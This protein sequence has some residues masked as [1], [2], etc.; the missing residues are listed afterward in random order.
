MDQQGAHVPK[1]LHET[2]DNGTADQATLYMP[3]GMGLGWQ[4]L[5]VKRI[6]WSRGRY[7][8]YANAINLVWRQ[9][10]QK[11][12]RRKWLSYKPQ[13]VI[14]A[15][16]GHPD[17]PSSWEVIK[18][19]Q[20][21]TIKR[22]K[23]SSFDPG[24]ASDFGQWLDLQG[25]TILADFREEETG[26]QG[27]VSL[28]DLG[29]PANA[30]P[31]P[32]I[33]TPSPLPDTPA[34]PD[35]PSGTAESISTTETAKLI[36]KRLKAD[37][38]RATFY[39]RSKSYSMGASI[40]VYWVDGPT[41][42][43]VK[44][45]AGDYDGSG[46]DGMIDL[47]YYINHWLQPDGSTI[48]AYTSGTGGSG[49][50]N[51]AISNPKPHKK[52]R[53]VSFGS[54][55]VSISRY[56]SA[57]FLQEAGARI[58]S[59]TGWE[60][61][62]IEPNTAWISNSKQLPVAQFKY[63]PDLLIPG[64]LDH[65]TLDREFDNRISKISAYK[66]PSKPKPTPSTPDKP[67]SGSGSITPDQVTVTHTS[68]NG[69]TWTW[70]ECPKP[71][72]FIRQALKDRGFRWSWKRRQWYATTEISRSAVLAIL[73]VDDT[74]GAEPDN[75]PDPP[76]NGPQPD[77]PAK[78]GTVQD[79]PKRDKLL[80]LATSYTKAI[81]KKRSTFANS[82]LTPRRARFI[83]SANIDA[84][85]MEQAQQ[86]LV[87]LADLWFAGNVPGCL[88]KVRTKKDAH[89]LAENVRTREKWG[90]KYPSS[91]N[92]RTWQSWEQYN[93]AHD[94]TKDLLNGVDT[95]D[96][97]KLRQIARLEQDAR[98]SKIPG[99]FSTPEPA[100]IEILDHLDLEAGDRVLEPSAGSGALADATLQQWP[101]VLVDVVE[102]SATLQQILK[103]KGY[104]LIDHDIFDLKSGD[105]DAIVMNPP[106]ERGQDI[107]HVRHCYTLLKP[108]GTLVSIMA[109]GTFTNGQNKAKDFRSWLDRVGGQKFDLPDGSFMESGTGVSSV[110]I[111][112]HKP[113]IRPLPGE[114]A[115]P[116]G[117]K[118]TDLPNLWKE[119]ARIQIERWDQ[120][121]AR[122]RVEGHNPIIAQFDYESGFGWRE[123]GNFGGYDRDLPRSMISASDLH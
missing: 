28:L 55:S 14:V 81:E 52:S 117:L 88:V 105:Y 53:L 37:Y 44:R 4:G 3:G 102:R 73:G 58:A 65:Q 5:E 2:T 9:P 12:D 33:D 61:P 80:K 6:E 60:V 98:F 74:P 120:S 76:G 56:Y 36:R 104:A 83:D 46:F 7:A 29:K 40:S 82:N 114:I 89:Q 78:P 32:A 19:D 45:I 21:V 25:F 95:G 72:K 50:M 18:E 113:A 123:A 111:V 66:A 24:W 69:K 51:S 11:K 90:D 8:Q 71:A 86:I 110:Y 112:I 75:E 92:E 63:N 119:A 57:A 26:D 108:G 93:Q 27:S 42:D 23:Y 116:A 16:W 122:I 100:A 41:Q 35:R 85:L 13:A 17:P 15:G 87:A 49:G 48:I 99:Y 77:P 54:D 96:R 115:T 67:D 39:V 121:T 79:L 59:E 70:I 91:Y 68:R 107:E 31:V 103:L 64:G 43:Q 34:L 1:T 38:P 22:G 101:G 106:F 47:K 84:D 94:W 62:A 97:D 30:E 109:P 20:E 118:I 10:R